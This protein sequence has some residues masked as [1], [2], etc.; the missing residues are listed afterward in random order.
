MFPALLLALV[1][2]VALLLFGRAWAGPS[3]DK[4]L[5]RQ[6]IDLAVRDQAAATLLLRQHPDLLHARTLHDQTLL[7]FCAAEG[8]A[9]GVRFLA[10]AGVPVDATNEVGDTALVD[11]VS[12]GDLQ[13]ARLLLRLGASPDAAS[14]TRGCVLHIAVGTG[15]AALVEALL[16]AGAR[17]DYV[18]SFGETLS[19]ALRKAGPRRAELS[20]VLERRSVS[21]VREAP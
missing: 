16:G 4:R 12:Q 1:G 3:V 15:N 11:A 2:G 7:H 19:D 6:L 9:E 8:Q 5:V 13:M 14:R 17:A 21:P 20:Q 10:R 18:T